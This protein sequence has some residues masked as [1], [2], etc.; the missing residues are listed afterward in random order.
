MY[1]QVDQCNDNGACLIVENLKKE[2]IEI[3]LS[4]SSSKTI[5]IK[6][7]NNEIVVRAR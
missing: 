7:L 4:V 1:G 6:E 2:D 5:I 3:K